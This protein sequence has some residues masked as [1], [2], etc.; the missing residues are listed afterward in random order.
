M[1]DLLELRNYGSYD[2]IYPFIVQIGTGGTGGYLVQNIAQMMATFDVKGQYLIADPDII[3]KK[4]LQNQL[5]TEDDVGKK[6]ADVLANR[7]RRA[8]DIP[9]RSYNNT[10]IEDVETLKSLFNLDYLGYSI[11]G[12]QT[13]YLPVIIGAVDNNFTRK[14]L[15]QFFIESG[16]CLY[17]DVGNE[18]AEV[19]GDYPTRNMTEWSEG[20]KNIYQESGWRGQVVCGLKVHGKTILPPVGSVFP[21]ILA[22]KDEIAPSQISCSDITATDP[23]RILTNKMAAMSV[24]PYLNSLF[25]EGKIYHSMTFFHAKKGYIQSQEIKIE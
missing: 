19:P 3:E 17:I 20:E 9:I 22:D 12:Y 16:R 5:F 15:H 11:N 1:I 25:E 24:L 8:Y 21:D 2:R 13:L 4:N 10:Y 18:S 14:V 6:K 23:Q 7:Y